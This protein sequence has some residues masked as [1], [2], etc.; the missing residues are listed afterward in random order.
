MKKK[1]RRSTDRKKNPSFYQ[2]N[3]KKIELAPEL[4]PPKRLTEITLRIFRIFPGISRRSLKVADAINYLK[5]LPRFSRFDGPAKT[6]TAILIPCFQLGIR[7]SGNFTYFCWQ[8]GGIQSISFHFVLLSLLSQ[9]QFR[10]KSIR[11]FYLNF[12]RLLQKKKKK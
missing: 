2:A 6:W 3:L 4:L 10:L 1:K 5:I 7:F 12:Y 11:M 9:M 8:N